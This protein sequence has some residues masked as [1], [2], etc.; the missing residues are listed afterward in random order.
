MYTHNRFYEVWELT[1]RRKINFKPG[2]VYLHRALSKYKRY[3]CKTLVPA[4]M[5]CQI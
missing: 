5:I 1:W 2:A 4:Y 3:Q